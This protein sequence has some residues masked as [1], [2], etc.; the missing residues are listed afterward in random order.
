[1][2]KEIPSKTSEEA[3]LASLHHLSLA[4]PSHPHMDPCS[5]PIPQSYEAVCMYR[6]GFYR[7]LSSLVLWS[8]HPCAEG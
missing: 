1:M 7:N 5:N 3:I 8:G 2:K 4:S 6:F